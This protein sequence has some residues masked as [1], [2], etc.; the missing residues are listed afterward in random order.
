MLTDTK[1][2]DMF[3]TYNVYHDLVYWLSYIGNLEYC[4]HEEGKQTDNILDDRKKL[5]SMKCKCIIL[6]ILAGLVFWIGLVLVAAANM[7]GFLFFSDFHIHTFWHW[8][9][10]QH[11]VQKTNLNVMLLWFLWCVWTWTTYRSGSW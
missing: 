6:H 8:Q 1:N 2:T 9:A 4:M 11:D 10:R 7:P 5:E 3:T